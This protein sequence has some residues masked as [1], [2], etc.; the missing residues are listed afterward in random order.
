MSNV[1]PL[2]RGQPVFEEAFTEAFAKGFLKGTNEVR[3]EELI[4]EARRQM[5]RADQDRKEAEARR[6]HWA[7]EHARLINSRPPEIVARMERERG[8]L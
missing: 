2:R 8:L 1:V 4:Q 7:R 3:L 5:L 6:A